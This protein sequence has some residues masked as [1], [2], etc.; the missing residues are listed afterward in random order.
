MTT[1]STHVGAGRWLAKALA[2]SV[3]AAG[4]PVDAAEEV[5]LN[6]KE[7]AAAWRALDVKQLQKAIEHADVTIGAFLGDAIKI[8]ERLVKSSATVPNGSVDSATR[9]RIFANGLL[10]DVGSCL[11]IKGKALE[12]LERRD[13]AVRVYRQLATLTYARTWD[14]KGW[15]WSPADAASRRL[16][17]LNQQ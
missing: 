9:A 15:F 11:F 2:L 5:P 13:E 1:Q 17:E 7:T 10:N 8:Q 12:G 3:I 14:P 4:I 6:E 16:S